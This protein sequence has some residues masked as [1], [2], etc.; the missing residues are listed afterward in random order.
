MKLFCTSSCT[1]IYTKHGPIF[2]KSYQWSSFPSC[3][4]LFSCSPVFVLLFVCFFAVVGWVI[5]CT[6]VV[7]QLMFLV[8]VEN[9]TRCSSGSMV[10]SCRLACRDPNFDFLKVFFLW[11]NLIRERLFEGL[12][13]IFV[14][15]V[16]SLVLESVM[17]AILAERTLGPKLYGIFPEGRLEQYI[18][19]MN[20]SGREYFDML[21]IKVALLLWMWAESQLWKTYRLVVSY[22]HMSWCK[23]FELARLKVTSWINLCSGLGSEGLLKCVP[24]VQITDVGIAFLGIF[25]FNWSLH[26]L[27]FILQWIKQSLEN[28]YIDNICLCGSPEHPH[29][30]RTTVRSVHL[31]WD[32]R[33]VGTVPSDG[34]ALQQRAKVAVWDHWQVCTGWSYGLLFAILACLN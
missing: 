20:S 17:F 12:C 13:V 24:V 19:V 3:A 2:V 26:I 28:I 18:P 29:V 10:P 25:F 8:W 9:H 5:C 31:I 14:Q 23:C 16:D 32:R 21:S 27:L 34:Y 22:I 33:Q 30:H 6:C 15:G 1:Y 4:V 11:P 7:Y